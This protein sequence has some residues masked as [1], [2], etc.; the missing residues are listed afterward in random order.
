MKEIKPLIG[1]T[2][3]CV[4]SMMAFLAVV[5]PIIRKLNLQE[6]HAGVMV[7]LAGIAW[8]F[9]S[10]FWG[11]KSDIF[12]RKN[13]LL[14][15]IFGFFISYLLLAIFVNY[16]VITPPLVIISFI[17]LIITRLL[18][19]VFYSAIP[20]VCNALIADKAK[21]G[22][23][24][25][26]MAS[27]GASNG[28]GMILGPIIGGALATYGL[29]IPLYAAAILPLFAVF[30]ALFFLEKDRKI[31]KIKDTPL[32]F[33]DKRLRLPMIAS[34]I[35]MFSIVTSQICLGFFILDRFQTNEI[36]TA[37]ITGYILAI[38]GVVFILTQI[39][40]SKL[41]S[42]KPIN[43][44]TLGATF[45][46]IGYLLIGII[47]TKEE[48]TMAF[49]I[50]TIGL[51]MIMPAFLA[52]TANSVEAHEQGIAAGTVSSAQGLGI[53]VG[54]LLST[55]LYSINPNFPF[56]FAGITFIILFAVSLL[57][58]KTKVIC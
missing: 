50:G 55:I 40:V 28:L 25:S 7:A 58:K 17:V 43:W 8:I 54:P 33:L 53:I 15:S 23:R 16:A 2:I 3:L 1:I 19:G 52:I 36:E 30:I 38:I 35:T 13:I 24:T 11:K 26:Y 51:G 45:S 44:L 5:G 14:L 27:L 20:P 9:L 46:A 41:K 22:K 34:F 47:T 37:K 49:C 21:S 12:G 10:R 31:E 18:I 4:S 48:L 29:A 42:V 6:W 57:Y 56:V 32:H 39:V